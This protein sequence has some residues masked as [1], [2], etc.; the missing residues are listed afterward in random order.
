MVSSGDLFSRTRLATFPGSMEPT[1][2]SEA[3]H[4][5]VF[6]CRSPENLAQRHA[7]AAKI[8]RFQVLI[9]SREIAVARGRGSIGAKQET[10]VLPSEFRAQ[11]LQIRS[12]SFPQSLVIRALLSAYG[13]SSR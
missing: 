13:P 11:P 1:C 3:E 12:D 10:C 7:S 9:Q 4:S 5:R 2:E 6:E 8:L